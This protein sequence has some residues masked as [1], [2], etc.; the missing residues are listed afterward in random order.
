MS[1]GGSPPMVIIEEGVTIGERFISGGAPVMLAA[2]S[3]PSVACGAHDCL[4]GE[5]RQH[6]GDRVR[7]TTNEAT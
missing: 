6:V 2:L 4:A 7:A 1:E 5:I 3:D